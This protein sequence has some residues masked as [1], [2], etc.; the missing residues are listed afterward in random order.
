MND[1]NHSKCERWHSC[2]PHSTQYLGQKLYKLHHSH[3]VGKLLIRL[4]GIQVALC[5]TGILKKLHLRWS[6]GLWIDVHQEKFLNK[7]NQTIAEV[8]GN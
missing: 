1:E 4:I 3:Y 8:H 6:E 7:L 2:Q 5:C